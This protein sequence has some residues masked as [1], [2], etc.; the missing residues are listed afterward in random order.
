LK[1]SS[2]RLKTEPAGV[3]AITRQLLLFIKLAFQG[4]TKRAF[5]AAWLNV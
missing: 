1:K 2:A 5:A 3:A 4:K